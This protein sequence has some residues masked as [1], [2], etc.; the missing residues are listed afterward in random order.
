M[1]MAEIGAIPGNGVNRQ[2]LSP[3]DIRARALL[4]AWAEARGFDVAVDGAANLFVRRAGAGAEPDAAPVVT[5]SHLDSQPQGGRFDGAFGVLAGFEALEALEDAGVATRRPIEV[6]SWTNEEGGR[7]APG[8]MGS[9]IFTGASRLEDWL[10][11]R[12]AAGVRLG[13]ALA[14]TLAA[15]PGVARRPFNL[16]LA[17]YVEAH[18]EQGPRL[19]DT[20]NAVGVVTGIQGSRWFVV[21]VLGETAHAGT[22]P[23]RGRRDAV[24]EAV[25]MIAALEELMLDVEDT[26]RFTVGRLDVR[27]NVPNSVPARVAFS[28][29]F[30]HPDAAVLRRLGDRIELVCRRAARACSVRVTETFHRMPCAFRR[31]MIDTIEAAARALGL[32]YLVM[33]SGAFHDAEFLHAVC[34]TGM[35]FVPC[36]RGISHNP[37]E[38]AKPEDLAAGTRVLAATLVEL[39]GA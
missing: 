35:I 10:D 34:P 36:E 14:G 30:R 31:E 16:P 9:A 24:R 3:E 22:A 19:E 33:P 38:N 28:I 18:I 5:G 39:A 7:Y 25:A 20:G 12:D 6:V 8:T 2:A 29:D 4:I 17:A 26:V 27:P 1:E 11:K 32:P 21:E 15:T 13:D 23:L 37:A